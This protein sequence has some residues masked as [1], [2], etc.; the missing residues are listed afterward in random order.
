MINYDGLRALEAV[1][2]FQS[3]EKAATDLRVTQ[4]AVSQRIG[5]LESFVG[6]KVL[7]RKSPYRPTAVG[8]EYLTLLRRVNV[9]ESEFL[10]SREESRLRTLNIAINKDSLDLW[11]Y[12]FFESEELA[13]KLIVEI[14]TDDQEFTLDYVKSGRSDMCI[15]SKAKPLPNYDVVLLGEM[16]YRLVGTPDFVR[17]FFPRGL[18]PEA[19]AK[20]PAVIFDEKD[21]LHFKFFENFFEYRGEFPQHRVPSILGYKK[22]ITSGFGYGLLPLLDIECELKEGVVVPMTP[23]KS[24][25]LPLYLHHWQYQTPIAKI[26]VDHIVEI[27]RFIK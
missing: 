14:V 20:A 17:R 10:E 5:N 6:E 1:I 21:L 26:V 27:S 16:E 9:L 23:G 3:F 11:F 13:G 18:N 19:L 2:R 25:K 8:R 22:A 4:S 12:Q 24:L 7:I 15:S